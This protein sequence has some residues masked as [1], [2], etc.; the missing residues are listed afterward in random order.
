[1]QSQFKFIPIFIPFLQIGP[2]HQNRD[3]PTSSRTSG[4]GAGDEGLG[5]GVRS[6]AG[7]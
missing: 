3:P 6:A 4:K 1:M 2:Q 7:Q 5:D